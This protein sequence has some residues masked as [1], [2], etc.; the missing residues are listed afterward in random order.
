MPTLTISF[1]PASPAPANGYIVQYRPVGR[2]YYT[3][4]TPNPKTS[5]VLIEVPGKES[6]EGMIASDCGFG[7]GMNM[8]FF[9]QGLTA[10]KGRITLGCND[11]GCTEQSIT[12]M[13]IVFNEPVPANITLY[14]GDIMNSATG[15]R[16]SGSDIFTPPA[17]TIP[18]QFYN[19]GPYPQRHK[20]PFVINVPAGSTTLTAPLGIDKV[21]S[22]PMRWWYCHSCLSP[23]TDL[24][25]KVNTPGYYADFT[26]ANVGTTIHNV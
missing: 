14:M 16:Y 7:R 22:D 19:S 4:V 6:Y 11:K 2:A 21:V 12:S 3:T 20:S 13:G 9:V 1:T 24:Y 18:N 8:P 25:V 5:P 23:I 10:I 15:R 26:V 17:G